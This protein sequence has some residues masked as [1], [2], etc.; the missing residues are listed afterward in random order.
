MNH[1][2]PRQLSGWV[3]LMSAAEIPVQSATVLAMEE[4]R[5]YEESVSATAV[6][7]VILDD[8]LMTL[9]L[10]VH[11]ARTCSSR[12]ITDVETVNAAVVLIGVPPL[13]RK[14]QAMTTV[15]SLLEP[16]PQALEGLHRVVRRAHRAARFALGLAVQRK[17]SEAE[18]IHEA[19]LLH[20]F[21]E[22]LLWCH[23]PQLALQIQSR[24]QNDPTLRSAQVQREVLGFELC[25]LEHALMQTWKM[26]ELL[27]SITND[28][29][30]E[31]PRVRNVMLAAAVA[32]HSQEGWLNPALADDFEAVGRLLNLSAQG[33]EHR[34]MMLNQD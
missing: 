31:N 23:A 18:V 34:V 1:G 29:R 14:F 17:D 21:A 9:R 6:S 27:V 30:S 4:L 28:R 19:A 3:A 5:Q 15:E 26:P 32:R 24:Q 11:L 12:L 8:P 22:M 10:L 20:D 13:L 2:S 7:A 16:W 25:D 33:A